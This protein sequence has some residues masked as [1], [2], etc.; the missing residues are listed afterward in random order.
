MNCYELSERLKK[1]DQ[2][3]RRKSTGSPK[4]LAAKLGISD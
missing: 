4:D 2:L 3:I 1:I